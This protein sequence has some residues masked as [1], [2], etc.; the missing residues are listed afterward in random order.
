MP[1]LPA[2]GTEMSQTWSLLSQTQWGGKGRRGIF[3]QTTRTHRSG[4]TKQAFST[5]S[6]SVVTTPGM[7]GP[8]T[9]GVRGEQGVAG[10]RAGEE[11]L[12]VEGTAGA[13]AG[14]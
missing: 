7:E 14:R 5:G 10:P 6:M 11:A 13:K 9:C 4:T 12:Q 1:A 3:Q 2:W 8:Q